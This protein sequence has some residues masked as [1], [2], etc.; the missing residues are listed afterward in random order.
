MPNFST[1]NYYGN[2]YCEIQR[3][4]HEIATKIGTEEK[5]PLTLATNGFR[6]SSCESGK[7]RTQN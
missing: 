4:I 6:N 7:F 3:G 2:S 5:S 1:M